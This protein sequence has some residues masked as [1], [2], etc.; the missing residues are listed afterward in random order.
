MSDQAQVDENI[1]VAEETAADSLTADEL[2][3]VETV[4]NM[5]LK[6]IE[7]PCTSCGYCMPCPHGVNI[8]ESFRFYN[9]ALMFEDAHR[10]RGDY[11]RMFSDHLADLCIACGECEPKCAQHIPIITSLEMVS[12]LF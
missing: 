1:A 3:A 2:A 12:V 11:R 8:P 7:V 6:K 5:Y 4:K 9:N 10:Y